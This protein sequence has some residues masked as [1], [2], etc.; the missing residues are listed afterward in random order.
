METERRWVHPAAAIQSSAE[1]IKAKIVIAKYR[2]VDLMK[3]QCS[4][5]DVYRVKTNTYVL[6]PTAEANYVE[7]R[8]SKCIAHLGMFTLRFVNTE[9]SLEQSCVT[10]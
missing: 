1:K 2:R 10:S 8:K 4:L 9:H 7:L 3:A 5:D 6:V